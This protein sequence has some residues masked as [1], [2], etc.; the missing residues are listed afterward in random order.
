MNNEKSI[1]KS[2]IMYFLYVNVFNKIA[3]E[4]KKIINVSDNKEFMQV[5]QNYYISTFTSDISKE[6]CNKFDSDKKEGNKTKFINFS[7]RKVA[8]DNSFEINSEDDSIKID[9]KIRK[10]NFNSDSFNNLYFII[11]KCLDEN[12]T[13]YNSNILLINDESKFES[14]QKL[15]GVKGYFK[16]FPKEENNYYLDK[17]E[18]YVKLSE[19]T[20]PEFSVEIDLSIFDKFEKQL[21]NKEYVNNESNENK[22]ENKITTQYIKENILGNEKGKVVN[23]KITTESGLTKKQSLRINDLNILCIGAYKSKFPN[24]LINDIITSKWKSI[25]IIK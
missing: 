20:K 3:N 21:S 6:L 15:D 17:Y 5:L 13:F 16:F 14:Y 19:I 12:E 7:I 4:Q 1:V 24:Y 9:S 25:E 22:E 23:V 10:L 18:Y 8:I 2:N 11:R